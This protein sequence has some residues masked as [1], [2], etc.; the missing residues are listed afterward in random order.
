MS[1][2]TEILKVMA[3]RNGDGKIN[4]QDAQ[5]VIDATERDA[6]L[7]VQKLS[8]VGAIL[9]AA[10]IGFAGGVLAH[11]AYLAVLGWFA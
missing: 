9:S 7:A 4:L 1:K 11:M 10:I 8:P 3:D 6:A 5:L 2:A